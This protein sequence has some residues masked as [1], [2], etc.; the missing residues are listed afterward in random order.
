MKKVCR[1][2][3]KTSA[4]WTLTLLTVSALTVLSAGQYRKSQIDPPPPPVE[5]AYIDGTHIPDSLIMPSPVQTTL[6]QEYADYIGREYAAD[7]RDPSNIK[8]EVEYDPVTRMFYLHTKLGDRDIV[9]PYMMTPE[10]YNEAMTRK[11]MFGYFQGRNAEIFENKEKQAFNIF[12]MNFSLGPLEK[13][14]GPGGVRLTTQGSIQ[15]SMGIKSNK[16]DNP[17]LPVRSRRKTFSDF[18]QKIQ[19]TIAASVGDKLKF[20][21][22]YN[23]DA[24]FDFDSKNLKLN[25]EGKED[26]IIKNIE[27][28]NVSMTTGSSHPGR[29]A[30]HQVLHK[31]R[32]L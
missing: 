25:Y 17:A 8:T 27:A 30:D 32:Q 26:E 14:F 2:I 9:T 31:G 22:T 5:P 6:P 15:V 16:T 10:E 24:T 20:N 29:R 28:G 21:M 12:D 11:E 4:I 18:D 3:T 13:V 7:L 1:K 23:T 19:A